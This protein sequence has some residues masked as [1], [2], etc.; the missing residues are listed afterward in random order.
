MA[1]IKLGSGKGAIIANP[2][3]ST[4]I[5][6]MAATPLHRVSPV[7]RMMVST[8]QVGGADAKKQKPDG[9]RCDRHKFINDLAT[10]T[11]RL[12]IIP[13]FC[14]PSTHLPCQAASGA[15]AAAME[16]LR[17]Q[18]QDVLDGKPAV[19]KIFPAQYAFN[20]FSHNSGMDV[21]SGYNEEE[22]KV[23]RWVA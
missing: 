21:E 6:L 13:T 10:H 11:I 1:H 2:N 14:P 3:C 22:L 20:L 4:I 23:S 17:S 9:C 12:P 19:P 16:E 8:Y 5:A 7:K 18:T 15:G